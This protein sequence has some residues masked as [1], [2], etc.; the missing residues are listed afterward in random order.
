[1][2]IESPP[3][4]RL[5]GIALRQLERSDLRE[6]YD[7]LCAPAVVEHTSWNVHGIEDLEPLLSQYE[8]TAASAPCRL[9]IVD[10]TRSRLAG[11]IGFFVISDM[12]RTAELA[13]DLAPEYWG[14]GIAT[15]ACRAVTEWSYDTLRLVRVQ[16]T[17][18]ETNTR[19]EG[20]LQR[21]D[22]VYEGLLRAYRMVR[23]VPG[24]F[25]MYS[26]LST[27]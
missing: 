8:S 22:F 16:A 4:S 12:H 10:E 20:V 5:Q 27:D 1:M 2:R 18:L 24:N 3:A 21:C 25:K 6:W 7:Y 15:A 19:S 14:R 13:Y 26:R 11:T 23:G 9:A 17:V